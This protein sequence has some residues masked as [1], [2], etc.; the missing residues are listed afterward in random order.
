MPSRQSDSCCETKNSNL[1]ISHEITNERLD[2]NTVLQP[3]KSIDHSNILEIEEND[4]NEE[5][6]TSQNTTFYH[7]N[8]TFFSLSHRE[9]SNFVYCTPKGNVDPL[10]QTVRSIVMKNRQIPINDKK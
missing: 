5:T 4:Q 2:F 10:A 3:E 7:E 6:K 1:K 8:H 9:C